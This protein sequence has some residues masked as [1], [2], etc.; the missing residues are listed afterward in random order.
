MKMSEIL[1]EGISVLTEICLNVIPLGEFIIPH[2]K[3]QS[4]DMMY[5]VAKWVG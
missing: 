2:G 4:M 1:K 3:F 5:S